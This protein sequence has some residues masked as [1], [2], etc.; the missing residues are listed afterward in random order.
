MRK[1]SI[2]VTNSPIGGMDWLVLNG[3]GAVA[4]QGHADDMRAARQASWRAANLADT[5]TEAVIP[6]LERTNIID[7]STSGISKRA[8]PISQT[9]SAS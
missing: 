4:T 5:L 9:R 8:S 1:H 2:C 3:S 6:P 7:F